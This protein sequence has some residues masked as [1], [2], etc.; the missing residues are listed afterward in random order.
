MLDKLLA[1]LSMA[2][3]IVFLGIIL[4]FVREP[5]LFLVIVIPVGIA[6]YCVFNSF[7]DRTDGD[8]G[9]PADG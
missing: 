9:K 1:S 7:V 8:N 6:I 3:L 2:G 5:D 4:W